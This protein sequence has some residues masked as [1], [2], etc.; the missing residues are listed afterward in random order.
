MS[1]SLS[2]PHKE[3]ENAYNIKSAR[4]K[5]SILPEYDNRNMS[6]EFCKETSE[7]PYKG[8]PPYCDIIYLF[9]VVP[10]DVWSVA[11]CRALTLCLLLQSDERD[12]DGLFTDSSGD[13]KDG[14]SVSAAN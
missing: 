14:N 7:L 13:G 3:T 1:R 10:P 6:E 5:L 12:H 11:Y 8:F 9:G 4:W 2:I